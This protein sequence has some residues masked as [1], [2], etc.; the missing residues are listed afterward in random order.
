MPR[1]VR[2]FW[3]DLEVDGRAS[4]VGSGPRRRDG[5]LQATFRIRDEGGISKK[6]ICVEGHEHDGKL[7]LSAVLYEDGQSVD[8]VAI[9]TKR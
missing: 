8:S 4:N 9:E 5:G 2:N 3:V 6:S 7:R 1:N